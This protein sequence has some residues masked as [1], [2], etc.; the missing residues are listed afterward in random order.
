MIG[1][2]QAVGADERTRPAVVKPH[3]GK[4]EMIEPLLRGVKVVFIRQL[5]ER[6]IVK[7]PHA[8]FGEKQRRKREEQQHWEQSNRAKITSKHENLTCS[9][10]PI[11]ASQLR[12]R[13]HLH[14][15]AGGGVF[16]V[17]DLF[18]GF[19]KILRFGERNVGKN[20][21]IAVGEREP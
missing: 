13:H 17:E 3:A 1:Q 10:A 2:Q 8:F 6:R 5:L 16:L 20:L 7:R 21:R 18:G 4:P 14:L 15:D 12:L 11:G 9:R 19:S